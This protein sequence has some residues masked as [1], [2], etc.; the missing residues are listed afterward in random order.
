[1][2]AAHGALAVTFAA[3]YRKRVHREV[4]VGVLISRLPEIL[5]PRDT[6]SESNLR[7]P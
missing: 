5:G 7:A 2:G 1:M 3:L 6:D 4:S